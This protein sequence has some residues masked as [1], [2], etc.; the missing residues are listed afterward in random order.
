MTKTLAIIPDISIYIDTSD[1]RTNSISNTFIFGTWV[2]SYVISVN[3]QK[4]LLR[5]VLLHF[6]N[7]DIEDM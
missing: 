4:N 2:M 5:L 6:A 1:P 7:E 3:V